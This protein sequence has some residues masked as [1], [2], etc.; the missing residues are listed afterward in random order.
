MLPIIFGV[1]GTQLSADERTFFRSATPAGYI[2]FK[3]NIVDRDQLRAL[4]DDLRALSGRDKLPI[5][6]DQE[7]GRVARM[8]PPIWPNFPSAAAFD[9]LYEVAP[10][11]AIEAARCNAKAIALSLH[12]VGIT[13]N[14]M[15]VLDLRHADTHASIRDRALGA[16]PL[17]VASLGR[18]VLNGLQSGGVTGVIKHMPGQGRATL[19]SHHHL[20]HV[21]ASDAELSIDLEPFIHLN[22]ARI[23][24]TGH[25]VFGEWDA[26]NPATMSPTIIG[27]IIRKRIGFE[28]L[29]LSDD[30]HMEALSGDI[31]TR[32]VDCLAAGCDI[33]LSCWARI[34]DMERIASILPK[35][36]ELTSAR[37]AA[38]G[39]GFGTDEEPIADL[40]SKRDALLSYV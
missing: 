31:V 39:T 16:D 29:L 11:S 4:T 33:A 10:M 14:C 2:L 26:D 38:A 37:L 34:G 8:M 27:D 7:G 23:G 13:V 20:P 36:R 40:I 32:V 3:H 5:L 25:V 17:R 30:L 22:D 19:D 21:D 24:M 1:S 15:P 35:M 9:A 12:D 28:G 18:A 6:I